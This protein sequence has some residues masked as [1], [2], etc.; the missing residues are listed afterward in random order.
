[1]RRILVLASSL[2]LLLVF[3]T[4]AWG[5]SIQATL[6]W[7]DLPT[8]TG[9][10]IERRAAPVGTYAALGTVN[11]NVLTFTD[12]A[13]VQGQSYCWRVV[14]FN[15]VGDGLP[16][17]EGCSAAPTAPCKVINLTIT[18]IIVP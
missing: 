16:S 6:N 17:D 9:Y 13:L 3:I 14:A 5:A 10:R 7:A 4:P 8:E 1:M 12:M 15:Q 2:A 11:A 18:I